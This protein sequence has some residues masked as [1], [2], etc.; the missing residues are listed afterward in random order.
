MVAVALTAGVIVA[1][2]GFASFTSEIITFEGSGTCWVGDTTVLASATFDASSL[3]TTMIGATSLATDL[4][5]NTLFTFVSFTL[6]SV[7]L[8]VAS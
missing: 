4:T 1:T 5:S 6:S 7:P 8:V 2:R 3:A